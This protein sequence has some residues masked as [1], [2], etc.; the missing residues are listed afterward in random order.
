M[1]QTSRIMDLYFQVAQYLPPEQ[2][3]IWRQIF[4]ALQDELNG[5]DARLT[6]HAPAL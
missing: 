3:E 4:Q 6:A 2:R 1:A 5:I